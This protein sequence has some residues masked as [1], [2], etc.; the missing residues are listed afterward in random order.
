MRLQVDDISGQSVTTKDNVTVRVDSC[1]YWKVVDPF[2]ASFLISN[3]RQALMERTQTILR[4]VFGSRLL[5]EVIEHRDQLAAECA[6]QIAEPAAGWG[7]DVEALL[8]KDILFSQEL[9]ETLSS[10][11]KQKRL[12]EGKVIQAMAEV[13]AAKLMRQ[14]ADVLATP[15]AMQI[16]YLDTIAGMA[17]TAGAKVIFVPG[18]AGGSFPDSMTASLQKELTSNH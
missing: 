14:A 2:Q 8:I 13:E 9:Q 15:A 3:V 17:K 11:A 4:H 10:A 7:V 18:S 5:Q 16:R 1:L 6:T 12:G